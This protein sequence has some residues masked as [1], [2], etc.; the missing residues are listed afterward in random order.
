[1][2]P[3]QAPE[4]PTP[5][6]INLEAFYR[7]NDPFGLEDSTQKEANQKA[8]QDEYKCFIDS[9]K[10]ANNPWDDAYDVLEKNEPFETDH[11]YTPGEETL[12]RIRS[13]CIDQQNR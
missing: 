9:L 5:G 4:G 13:S 3:G 12:G 10:M 7:F 1:M 2:T 6:A 11:G 8:V